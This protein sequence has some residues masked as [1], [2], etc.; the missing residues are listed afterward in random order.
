MQFRITRVS[1]FIIQ[2]TVKERKM[3]DD[4]VRR[5]FEFSRANLNGEKKTSEMFLGF[6]L[7]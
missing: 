5:Y 2:P 4:S 3:T 1:S 6:N 7:Q